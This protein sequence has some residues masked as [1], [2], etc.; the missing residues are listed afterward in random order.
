MQKTIRSDFP[1]ILNNEKSL[2][3]LDNAATT[4][5]PKMV[6]HRLYQYY[7]K[8]NCN[9]HR[10]SYPLSVQA[11][12][13][14]EQSRE[15]VRK[16]LDA[17]SS[18]EIVF[19]RGSTEAIN[20]AA[21]SIWETWV[22]KG[23]NCIVTELEHSSNYFPW[24]HQCERFETE[25]RMAHVNENG[26]LQAEEILKQ[27]DRKTRLIAVTAMSNVTGFRPNLDQIIHAAHENGTMVLVDASQ[28]AAHHRISVQKLGCDFLCFSGHKIYG[29]MGT[30]VLYAR[31]DRIREM[32]PYQYGGGMVK[33]GNGN[34]FAYQRYYQRFE[35]GTQDIGGV[36]G[37]AA[38]LEY[39]E[40]QGFDQIKEE[41]RKLSAYLGKHLRDC[42]GIHVIGHEELSPVVSFIP[43]RI[44]AYDL[45]V[46]LG[47]KGIAVRCG[48]HCAYPFA[49]RL[50]INGSCRIS[51]GCYNTLKE[52][53]K[54]IEYI[55]TIC[56]KGGV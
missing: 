36:L 3:Y 6:I 12:K 19:T 32:K 24:K 39:L 25:L 56:Q 10:G 27:M 26:E 16:W 2:I 50:G 21:S 11:E 29:P 7:M 51:L 49:K 30:G 53:D 4:Q 46:M 42:P 37:L 38:A 5:K 28:E 23:D 41:E 17:R 55:R 52:I 13:M 54:T 34:Q 43:E 40:V 14:Y 15:T 47:L 22:K 20:L 18:N 45:G 8:E 9:I 35:A 44:G 33:P 48:E 1:M 31:E